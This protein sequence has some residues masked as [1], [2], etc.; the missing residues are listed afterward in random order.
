MNNKILIVEDQSL[1]ATEIKMRLESMGYLVAEPVASGE[2]AIEYIHEH[3]DIGLILMD[4][5]LKGQL[6]GIE[7]AEIIHK[8][9]ELP[10]VF[11]TA[12]CDNL[13]IDRV[14]HP[15][16]YG[17]IVKPFQKND[18]RIGI[19][20]AM[21]RFKNQ[22]KSD[23]LP[24]KSVPE[25]KKFPFWD[26]HSLH[27]VDAEDIIFIEVS[28]KIIQVHLADA[29]FSQRSTLKE[30]EEK[31]RGSGFLRVHKNF[32]VNKNKIK[33]IN[34]LGQGGHEILMQGID[35]SIPVAKQKWK[36]LK[37]EVMM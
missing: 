17:Y 14:K 37:E 7:T 13:T 34:Q 26:A 6:D 36:R 11:L 16:T 2:E 33:N 29:V 12:M 10:V 22:A 9:Y 25:N 8:E 23:P 19:E 28:E 30:W 3:Q 20:L 32:M 35:I 4:I 31:L 21:S 5:Y 1:V 18:L 24:E 15:M 27:L